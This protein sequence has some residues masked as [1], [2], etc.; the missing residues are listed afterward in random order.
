M[1]CPAPG[2]LMG[3]DEGVGGKAFTAAIYLRRAGQG[4]REA[5]ESAAI[6][7]WRQLSLLFIVSEALLLHEQCFHRRDVLGTIHTGAVVIH[8]NDGNGNSVFQGTQLLEF[9][10]RFE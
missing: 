10:S 8:A 5:V 1:L 4:R 2:G 7:V 9:L 6:R 3:G